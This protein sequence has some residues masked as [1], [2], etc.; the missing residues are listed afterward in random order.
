MDV[1]TVAAIVVALLDFYIGARYCVKLFRKESTPSIATWIIFE[2]GVVMSLASYLAG[3]DHSLIK[4][5]M[6]VADSVQVS[7]IVVAIYIAQRGQRI[8]FS[9]FE[10]MSLAASGV[11]ALVWLLTK[12]GLVGFIA[13]QSVMS[14]AYVPTFQSL[15]RWRPGRSPEPM[16]KWGIG[17]LASLIGVVGDVTGRHDYVAM[18]YPLRA[19]VLCLV[20]VVLIWRWERKSVAKGDA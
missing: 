8:Q 6:N 18:V 16:E 5:A 4:A 13:F 12:Q 20:V 1:S 11:A 17:A 3:S 7:V 2:I 9:G 10:W 19:L 14:I 15:W